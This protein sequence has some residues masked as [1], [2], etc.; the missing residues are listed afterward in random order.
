MTKLKSFE[1]FIEEQIT[2]EDINERMCELDQH[3]DVL[4]EALI[5]FGG[6]AY[7]KFGNIVIMAG[8]AGSGK[9]F[10]KDKLL[11]LE[12]RVFDVDELKRLAAKAPL[13]QKKVKAETGK[14]IAAIASDLKN[15]KNVSD[16]H[17]IVG[18]VLS[19]D[20]K[21]KNQIWT[22]VLTAPAD[23]KPN[24]IFDVTLKN[25]AK[26]KDITYYADQ[27]GYDKKKIHIVWVVNDVE[28]AKK[29]NSKRSRV[30]PEDILVDTHKGAS[31]TMKQIMDMD[32]KLTNYMDGAIF[33][34]FNKVGVDSDVIISTD[35]KGDSTTKYGSSRITINKSNYVELK[36]PGKR[37]MT[38]DQMTNDFKRKIASY[39][40]KIK[41]WV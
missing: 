40:P 20:K 27:V 22:S 8:G 19:L 3:M 2:S 28:V 10:V 23:R 26:L 41:D 37:Q 21:R 25:L 6:K 29:Q 18:D 1:E 38:S 17:A 24:L 9:G 16:L 5:T 15:P 31:M 33:F 11:G 7:P 32:D 36:K 34:A 4:D 13:I 12:G 39:T 30:V 35:D 14:D